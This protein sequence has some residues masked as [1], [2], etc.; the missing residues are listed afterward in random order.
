MVTR[1]EPPYTG[2]WE[3]QA[4]PD[5][6]VLLDREFRRA[7]WRKSYSGVVD[8]YRECVA[9]NSAHLMVLAD[10]TWKVDHVDSYNPDFGLYI[11]HFFFDY[12][13]GKLAGL[14]AI[15][16]GLAVLIRRRS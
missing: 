13:P 6:V 16:T 9:Y 14:A 5:H 12:P 10:G 2:T 7:S 15:V 1:I 3:Y 8:Q 11:R 4:N